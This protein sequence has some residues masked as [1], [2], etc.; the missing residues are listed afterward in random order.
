M[1][2]FFS[3]LSDPRRVAFVIGFVLTQYCCCCLPAC[4]IVVVALLLRN[5]DCCSASDLNIVV[6]G[7]LLRVS[8]I[9]FCLLILYQAVLSLSVKVL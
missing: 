8:S 2:F 9:L 1:M 4:C 6:R 5:D 7:I 3:R